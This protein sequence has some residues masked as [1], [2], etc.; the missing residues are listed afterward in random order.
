MTTVL[1]QL[2]ADFEAATPAP[3]EANIQ[4][5][6]AA[7]VVAP[8]PCCGL[9][10]KRVFPWDA[11]AIVSAHNRMPLLLALA[12]AVSEIGVR[13]LGVIAEIIRPYGAVKRKA[14]ALVSLADAL[15]PLLEATE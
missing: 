12:E 5:Q 4:S 15:A 13:D 7:E 1:S 10:A 11:K 6:Y 9:V 2:R 3:W 8:C 14:S